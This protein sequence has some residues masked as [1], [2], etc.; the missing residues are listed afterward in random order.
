MCSLWD[1]KKFELS[2]VYSRG[3][4]KNTT[5]S[6]DMG[7]IFGTIY[8]S[9]GLG[10]IQSFSGTWKILRSSSKERPLAKHRTKWDTSRHHT[11]FPPVYCSGTFVSHQTPLVVDPT[12]LA[13]IKLTLGWWMQ[14][15]RGRLEFSIRSV[16]TI[17]ASWLKLLSSFRVILGPILC[18]ITL[19]IIPWAGWGIF[20]KL[21]L[22][23]ERNCFGIWSFKK[24]G[25][26]FQTEIKMDDSTDA[27][28]CKSQNN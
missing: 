28:C 6:R 20:N 12:V 17:V 16:P 23:E 4:W 19:L 8:K 14:L 25:F 5:Y 10:K 7:N 15:N 24:N 2:L 13:P 9:L 3:T 18:F 11:S 22:V 27:L 1:L 21:K 26:S